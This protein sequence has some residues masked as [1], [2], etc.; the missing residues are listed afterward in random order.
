MGQFAD[1]T[2]G[3]GW[4][5]EISSVPV[6]VSFAVI[7]SWDTSQYTARFATATGHRHDIALR[8]VVEKL[9]ESGRWDWTVWEQ[10]EATTPPRTGQADFASLATTAAET[11]ARSWLLRL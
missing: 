8:L 2:G 7:F 10:G 3:P 4:R 11:T 9:P 5:R 6:P 1:P